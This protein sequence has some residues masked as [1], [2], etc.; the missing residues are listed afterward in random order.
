VDGVLLTGVTP[1]SPA[2][3]AGIR[4]GDTIIQMGKIE[5]HSLQDLQVALTSHKPGDTV[6]V[7]VLRDKEK[8]TFSVA[9]TRRTN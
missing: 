9:L 1:G 6:D 8:K 5:V 7:T 3:K 2:D 4:A